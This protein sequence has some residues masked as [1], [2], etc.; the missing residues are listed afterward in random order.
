MRINEIVKEGQL[1]ELAP[2]IGVAARVLAP[3]AG[4]VLGGTAARGVA[5]TAARAGTSRLGTT[6]ATTAAPMAIGKTGSTA[7]RASGANRSMNNL[8]A[9]GKKKVKNYIKN[10][11]S[12]GGDGDTQ[13]AADA[14]KVEKDL[15]NISK[16][17]KATGETNATLEKRVKDLEN[18]LVR[19]GQQDP[20]AALVQRLG[21][22][23]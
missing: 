18:E 13:N 3:L 12:L 7:A 10:K 17:L 1:D 22:G 6:A 20:V 19:I 14:Q 5:G 21:G 4:R 16:E 9:L 11:L 15:D 8:K 2:L 23:R